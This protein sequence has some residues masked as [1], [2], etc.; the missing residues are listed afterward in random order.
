L[1]FSTTI[2]FWPNQKGDVQFTFFFRSALRPSHTHHRLT[3]H[4]C[5]C[6]PRFRLCRILRNTIWF[7][8][9]ATRPTIIIKF[10]ALPSPKQCDRRGDATPSPKRAGQEIL[11]LG[12][13]I[14]VNYLSRHTNGER[15]LGKIQLQ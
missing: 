5:G 2:L 11:S 9:R 14:P 3:T 15:K 13:S 8:Y 12:N 4:G 6:P 7:K 10:S 1:N